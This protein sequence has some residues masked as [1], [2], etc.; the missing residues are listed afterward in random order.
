MTLADDLARY[1][2]GVARARDAYN[3]RI[4]RLDASE[5]PDHQR[6]ITPAT[7]GTPQGAW[8]HHRDN[9]PLCDPCR[10]AKREYE[11]TRYQARKE[12]RR[13]A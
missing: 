5:R 1:N 7:C 13:A 11:R 10:D 9:E 2:A 12:A 4:A 3:R 8:R 6:G